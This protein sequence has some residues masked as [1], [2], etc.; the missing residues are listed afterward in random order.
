ME[1]TRR[2]KLLLERKWRTP[3]IQEAQ[4]QAYQE[5]TVPWSGEGNSRK[6]TH[7]RGPGPPY[8]LP[9]EPHPP[10][11]QGKRLYWSEARGLFYWFNVLTGNCAYV[12]PPA[13][14]LQIPFTEEDE[15]ELEALE[16]PPPSEDDRPAPFLP[17]QDALQIEQENPLTLATTPWDTPVPL[18]L[19]ATTPIASTPLIGEAPPL[20]RQ[21]TPPKDSPDTPPQPLQPQIYTVH[22]FTHL[23][24]ALS[25]PPQLPPAIINNIFSFLGPPVQ[26]QAMAAAAAAPPVPP[27]G[28][29][30][31]DLTTQINKLKGTALNFSGTGEPIGFKNRMKLLIRTKNLT[32]A[33]DQLCEWLSHLSGQALT[34]AAPYFDDL[35]DATPNYVRKHTLQDFLDAFDRTYA[36]QNLQESARSKLSNLRQGTRTVGNYVQQFQSLIHHA[37]Y[38]E[39]EVLYRFLNGLDPKI[40]Y[41]LLLMGADQRLDQAIQQAQRLE[42]VRKGNTDPWSDPGRSNRTENRNHNN[43]NAQYVPMEIDA[44][45]SKGRPQVK[46]FGCGKLGH[47]K[48]NCRSMGRTI[49]K[50]PSGPPR[51]RATDLGDEGMPVPDPKIEELEAQLAAQ[52]DA[53]TTMYKL[54]QEERKGKESD[55]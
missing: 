43:N 23:P 21:P 18:L 29:T 52:Q 13:A 47:I 34:W 10:D 9:P 24:A 46:C 1:R 4:T 22:P 11:T 33:D 30:L 19:P 55:F 2:W 14:I 42:T 50:R 49:L 27:A 12:P 3:S 38:G 51:I 31:N 37:G 32:D 6:G 41:H 20:E 45:R 7:I 36:Y 35:F 28:V 25:A 40:R 26:Q 39:A 16:T 5:E 17:V 54:V 8:A 15:V 48:R 53:L 44:A